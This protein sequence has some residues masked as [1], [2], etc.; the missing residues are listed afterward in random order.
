M[1]HH[2]TIC[3]NCG[4]DISSDKKF[5]NNC[6]QKTDTHR[7]NFHFLVHELQHSILHVDKGILYTIKELF[8]RPGHTIR[9]YI[10]GKR[11]THFPPVTLIL[12]LGTITALINHYTS[13]S[14]LF[15]QIKVNLK[16]ES[17]DKTDQK[18]VEIL[19]TIVENIKAFSEWVNEHFGYL[20]LML[21]PIYA[22]SLFIGFYR[23]DATKRYNYVEYL[24]IS[25]FLT[26]QSMIIYML[27]LPF[28]HQSI[29]NNI[30]MLLMFGFNLWAVFQ[31]FHQN[32]KRSVIFRFFL[33]YSFLMFF[34]F[35]LIIAAFVIGVV[36]I[37]KLH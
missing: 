8:V 32:S 10:E 35:L 1:S 7:I 19:K 3:K 22:L 16:P 12:I 13:K 24:V 36:L 14:N 4:E 9:E 30:S 28:S 17:V 15:E 34:T 11:K 23:K 31:L 20:M 37:S 25:T 21:I 33:S 2:S 26:A 29:V 27:F 6:G 5:C 18:E